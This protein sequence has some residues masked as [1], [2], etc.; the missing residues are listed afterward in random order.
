MAAEYYNWRGDEC[1]ELQRDFVG[2]Q[3]DGW[4]AHLEATLLKYLYRYPTKTPDAPESDL[5]KLVEYAV[6][7]A[8]H[9]VP[10]D[11]LKAFLVALIEARLSDD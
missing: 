6:L 2:E 1:V 11:R 5:F 8:L 4:A 9:F 3:S 10:R 7:L